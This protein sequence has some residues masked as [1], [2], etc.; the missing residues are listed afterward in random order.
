MMTK[1]RRT[2]AVA[3][4]LLGEAEASENKTHKTQKK[5]LGTGCKFNVHKTFRRRPGPKITGERLCLV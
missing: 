5:P 3:C 1:R 4:L 2:I